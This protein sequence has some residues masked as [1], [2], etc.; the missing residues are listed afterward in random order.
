MTRRIAALIVVCLALAGAPALAQ[1]LPAL[2][3]PVNDLAHVIDADSARELDRR[4]RALETTTKDAVVVV[5]VPSYAPFG[6][7]EEYAVASVRARRHR[8]A[9]ARTTAC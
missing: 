2:T 4:I 1:S 5:T 7:I 8:P 3:G 6:S 9:R